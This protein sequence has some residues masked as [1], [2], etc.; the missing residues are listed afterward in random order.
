[1]GVRPGRGPGVEDEVADVVFVAC[2]GLPKQTD[3]LRRLVDR[4]AHRPQQLR[5]PEQ[6]PL[7]GDSV[8][9]ALVAAADQGRPGKAHRQE[10][11]RAERRYAEEGPPE[12]AGE[13]VIVLP[14]RPRTPHDDRAHHR[15]GEVTD[16]KKPG[17]AAG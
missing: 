16:R 10:P 9:G 13:K 17:P 2:D 8:E 14:K 7:V 11:D 5:P 4:E 6:G 15:P 3:Q 12:Y 1:V